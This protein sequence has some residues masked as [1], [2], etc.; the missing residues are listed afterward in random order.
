MEN[1]DERGGAGIEISNT[2][3]GMF[4]GTNIHQGQ[5]N[6]GWWDKQ[7]SVNV[8]LRF[9]LSWHFGQRSPPALDALVNMLVKNVLVKNIYNWVSS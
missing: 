8:T 2:A 6:T 4:P 1:G 3:R 9:I 5:F 7:K